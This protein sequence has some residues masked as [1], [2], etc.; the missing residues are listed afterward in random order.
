MDNAVTPTRRRWL[1][2]VIPLC[3]FLLVGVFLAI[4]LTRDP[5][6]LPSALIGKAAPA[7]AVAP[8]ITVTK[9]NVADGWQQS[10]NRAPPQS[11]LDALK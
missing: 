6:T 2:F 3:V 4:G 10:L 11:V 7:F 5:S 1:L 8:A 9:E